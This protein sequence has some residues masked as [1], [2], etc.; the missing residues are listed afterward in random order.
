MKRA[1]IYG[2][3]RATHDIADIG[4]SELGKTFQR[5]IADRMFVGMN[6]ESK[7]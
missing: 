3:I 4:D 6:G 7:L 2:A 1:Q 5:C